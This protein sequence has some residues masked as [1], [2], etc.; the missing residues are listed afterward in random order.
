MP[1]HQSP[2]APASPR[3][4]ANLA[5]KTTPSQQSLPLEGKVPNASEADDVERES[6]QDFMAGKSTATYCTTK[7]LLQSRT[8]ELNRINKAPP[9]HHRHKPA[10]T[11]RC[12]LIS[13]LPPPAS[14]QGEAKTRDRTQY[15]RNKAF[16][17]RGRCRTLV[18]R[19]RWGA[20]QRK[21]L[22]QRKS[23]LPYPAPRNLYR[24]PNHRT[25]PHKQSAAPPSPP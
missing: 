23:A 7:S 17:S 25:K 15:T 12:H 24:K 2:T 8:T 13:R 5:A 22:W 9:L 19:M 16:P 10:A 6:P 4:E 11:K 3:G 14:P 20:N 1:P 18:R 21:T